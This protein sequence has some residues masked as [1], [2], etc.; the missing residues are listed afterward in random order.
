MDW[1]KV[2]EI[3]E[4]NQ[5]FALTAHMFPDGD[6]LGAEFALY[7]HL[8]AKGKEVHIINNQPALPM[9][10]FLDPISVIEVY[11]E[12]EHA[13][14]LAEM[15]VIFIVDVSAW[16]YMGD[17]G[18]PVKNSPATKICIDH[19]VK[20]GKFADLDFINEKA[21]ATGELVYDFL[22]QVDGKI[23][24]PTATALY[25]AIITDTGVFRFSNTTTK[26]H[27]IAADLLKVGIDHDKI[28]GALYENS[29]WEKLKL[30]DLCFSNIQSESKGKIAW[31]LVTEKMIQESLA[32][33][34]DAD[35]L[36]DFVR[37]IQG[38]KI[39][40]IFREADENKIKV[41]FRSK[42]RIDVEKLA[43]LFGGGGHKLASGASI[44]GPSEEVVSRVLAETKKLV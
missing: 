36:I 10:H 43:I 22:K 7:Y 39:S 29:S 14:L 4:K 1:H 40:L 13:S 44:E 17:V 33:W 16:D 2:A 27:L 34:S 9:F 18:V 11:N 15:D 26:S 3:I 24:I 25:T 31:V 12:K 5:R 30:L 21:C 6:A 28:Y 42:D 35:G 32:T 19:H 8:K 20:V 37:T 23:D 38:V 41:H